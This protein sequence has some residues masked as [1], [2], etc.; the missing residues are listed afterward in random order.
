[1][2]LYG[3]VGLQQFLVHAAAKNNCLHNWEYISFVLCCFMLHLK[4]FIHVAAVY[5]INVCMWLVPDYMGWYS[6]YIICLSIKEREKLYHDCAPY[7]AP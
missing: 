7:E 5:N 4:A 2:P 1:M 6:G 3:I